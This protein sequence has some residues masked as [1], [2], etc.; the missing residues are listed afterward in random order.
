MRIDSK[1]KKSVMEHI[2][3]HNEYP[4]TK[5]DIIESCNE[6]SDVP[7]EER[8]WIE[9]SLPDRTY[10]ESNEVIRALGW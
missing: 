4:A 6:M 9:K 5:G 1:T 10:E 7:K 3:K 2:K 8:K